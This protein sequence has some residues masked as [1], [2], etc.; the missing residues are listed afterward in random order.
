[1]NRN[2]IYS[3]TGKTPFDIVFD[4]QGDLPWEK[5]KPKLNNIKQNLNEKF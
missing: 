2:T 1:M 4:R 3:T 5:L